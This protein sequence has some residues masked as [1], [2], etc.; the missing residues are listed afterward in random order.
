MQRVMNAVNSGG[1]S[2]SVTNGLIGSAI[3]VF[4]GLMVSVQTSS[5]GDYD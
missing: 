2:A 4:G 1:A 5:C 3:L